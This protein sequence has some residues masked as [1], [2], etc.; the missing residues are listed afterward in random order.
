MCSTISKI[1]LI[2]LNG[3]L[4]L[5]LQNKVTC[6]YRVPQAEIVMLYGLF[7]NFPKHVFFLLCYLNGK[8][9]QY[10]QIVLQVNVKCRLTPPNLSTLFSSRSEE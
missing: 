10:N 8:Y 4:Q 3:G 7:L 1:S 6:C 2:V 5:K 9:V